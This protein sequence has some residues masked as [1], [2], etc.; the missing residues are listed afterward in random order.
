MSRSPLISA[1]RAGRKVTAI[2]FSDLL[3]CSVSSRQGRSTVLHNPQ[4]FPATELRVYDDLRT[5]QQ[6]HSRPV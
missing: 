2:M 5:L 6:E 4:K 3:G 1:T